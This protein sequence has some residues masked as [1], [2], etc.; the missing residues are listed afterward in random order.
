MKKL[1]LAATALSV[2]ASPVLAMD[3]SEY[4]KSMDVLCQ[5]K[6]SM[7]DVL[8]NSKEAG[9]SKS[10]LQHTTITKT[11]NVQVQVEVLKMIE[12]VFRP[13]A[14]RGKVQLEV[15]MEC[16]NTKHTVANAFKAK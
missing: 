7:V 8:F 5:R 1:I 9:I 2:V 14:E 3:T 11:D 10:L 6:G 13:G 4:E 15:V 12:E 16:L